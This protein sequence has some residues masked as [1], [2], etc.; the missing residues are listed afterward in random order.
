MA[1]PLLAQDAPIA[2]A[3]VEYRNVEA[4]WSSLG[5]AEAERQSTVSAQTSGRIVAINFRAGACTNSGIEWCETPA[6]EPFAKARAPHTA[7][8][9]NTRT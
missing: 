3:P 2:T 7:A 9:P 8:K 5:V 1:L 4:T 6:P